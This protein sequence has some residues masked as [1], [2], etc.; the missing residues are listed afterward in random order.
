MLVS[1]GEILQHAYKNHYGVISP[2]IDGPD[3]LWMA[4]KAAEEKKSPLILGMRMEIFKDVEE[5]KM[6]VDLARTMAQRASVPVSI[7][8]DHCKD[9]KT[10]ISGFYGGVTSVML[11]YS[12]KSFEENIEGTK[13]ICDMCHPIGVSVEAELGHLGVDVLIDPEDPGKQISDSIYTVPSEAG[14]FVK[15]TGVDALAIAIGNKHGIYKDDTI[16]HI[17]FELLEEINKAC[18]IP[19]VLHGGSGTG[20]DNLHKAC[21]M[22]VCKINVGADVRK[23]AADAVI[24]AEP[25][26]QRTK[27]F[28]LTRDGYLEKTKYYMDCFGSTDKSW[29]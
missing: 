1:T 28:F 10:A 16:P 19:L 11:D 8:F 24:N 26:K 2:S 14:E 18:G 7:N 20:D 6:F 25:K 13:F 12:M 27:G 9:M 22:G 5:L 4:V 21:T 23:A 15:R 17:E 3:C 29:L